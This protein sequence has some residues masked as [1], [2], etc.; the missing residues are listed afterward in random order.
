MPR[1]FDNWIKAYMQ[2]AQFS[3]A[4]AK[5]H[6]WTAASVL[7]GAIR[8]QVWIDQRYFQWTPNMY[9]IFVAPPGIISKTTTANIGMNLLREVPGIHFGPDAVTWQALAQ[10]LAGSTEE[11]PVPDLATGE[12][13][14]HAMSALTIVSG[15]F[16]TFLDPRDREMVDVLV[17]L[18]DGQPGAWKKATKTAGNDLIINPWVNLIACTTPAWIQGNFPEY[19]IGGGFTSRCIFIY[20]ETKRQLIAYPG[21]RGEESTLSSLRDKLIEDLTHISSLRGE[22]LLTPE[23][24]EWGEKWYEDHYTKQISGE[25]NPQFASYFA[26]KQTHMHKLAIILA[27]AE[28]DEL[29]IQPQH[30]E[31]AL[32]MLTGMEQDFPRIFTHIGATDTGRITA[33]IAQIIAAKPGIPLS[34]LYSLFLGKL[35][36][37]EIEEG[38]RFLVQGGLANIRVQNNARRIYPTEALQNHES[39]A[40]PGVEPEVQNG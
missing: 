3:E 36:Q 35:S 13:T 38:I 11:F 32:N 17:S 31:M 26:R 7:A 6:F 12:I 20:G 40:R 23:A 39:L 34:Q 27:L 9:I 22:M 37:Q 14:Y 28:G 2:Y 4:P 19:M 8:R 18:W 1:N 10:A 21:L 29:T 33:S 24:V 25:T 5:F 15:E 30:L 16:G